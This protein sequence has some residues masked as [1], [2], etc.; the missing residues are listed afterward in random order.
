MKNIP[1]EFLRTDFGHEVY[2]RWY[3][4][5]ARHNFETQKHYKCC[6]FN[7]HLHP[8]ELKDCILE[9]GFMVFNFYTKRGIGNFDP[10]NDNGFSVVLKK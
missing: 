7:M 4:E 3:L 2:D 5:H 1:N 8:E 6:Y 9:A 10:K